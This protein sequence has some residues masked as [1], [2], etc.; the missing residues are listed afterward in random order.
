MVTPLSINDYTKLL[1]ETAVFGVG[2]GPHAD[3]KDSLD[4]L[5]QDMMGTPGNRT[6]HFQEFAASL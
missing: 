3:P 5:T 2:V 6:L 1:E 4:R